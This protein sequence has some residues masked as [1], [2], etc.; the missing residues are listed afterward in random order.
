M[1]IIVDFE[2]LVKDAM[3]IVRTT[4]EDTGIPSWLINTSVCLNATNYISTIRHSHC[5]PEGIHLVSQ[6][7]F[8]F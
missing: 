5:T 3:N 7:V 4:I 8:H 2:M 6:R 1:V